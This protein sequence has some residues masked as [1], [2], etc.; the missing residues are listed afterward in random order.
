MVKRFQNSFWNWVSML[1]TASTRMRRARP[2]GDQLA[3]QDARLQGLAEA[4]RI[5]NQDALPGP[6]K[7][8]SGGVEL[9]GHRVHRR[10]VPDV[11]VAVVGNGRAK[12]ALH[13]QEA[14][15]EPGRPV[16]N[17]ACERGVQ[18]LDLLERAQVDRLL[19]AN[20][21]RDTVAH[22][23]V[24]AVGDHVHAADDPLRVA[25]DDSGAEGED[26]GS[27]GKPPPR[28]PPCRRRHGSRTTSSRSVSS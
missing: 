14:V 4:D 9:I 21:L 11:D 24:R 16:E 27:G 22:E 25:D 3:Y 28:R 2:R 7:R 18:H 10:F 17:E 19:L 20:Q 5:G 13:V 26:E 12:L 15:R 1:F 6:S 23:L 8:L